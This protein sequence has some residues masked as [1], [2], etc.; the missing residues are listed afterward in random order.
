M[1]P[2]KKRILEKIKISEISGVDSPAQLGAVVAIMKR[3]QEP[4]MSYHALEDTV[5]IL[6]D[7][8]DV[9]NQNLAARAEPAPPDF[10]VIVEAIKKRDGCGGMAAL[11]KA[12]AEAPASFAAYNGPNG[13]RPNANAMGKASATA[14]FMREVEELIAA[15]STKTAAMSEARKR[16]PE[17]FAA[18]QKA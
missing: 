8:V 7:K 3:E 15:G 10:D 9:L 6:K 14:D 2:T 5:L 1:I 4:A 16:H 13:V 11:S 17:K 12:R 18:Y